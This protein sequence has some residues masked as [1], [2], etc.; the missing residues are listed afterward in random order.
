MPAKTNI[1]YSGRTNELKKK[2]KLPYRTFQTGLT[3]SLI[4][5]IPFTENVQQGIFCDDMSMFKTF[6][7]LTRIVLYIH[8][9]EQNERN[10]I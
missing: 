4:V 3:L 5:R 8:I 7:V 1:T 2:R 10:E 6:S 9:H